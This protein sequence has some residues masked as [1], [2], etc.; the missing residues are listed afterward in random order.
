MSAVHILKCH[1]LSLLDSTVEPGYALN[2]VRASQGMPTTVKNAKVACLDINLQRYKMQM[3]VQVRYGLS[4]RC[5]WLLRFEPC[6]CPS[7]D[8][9]LLWR[10]CARDSVL[11][12]AAVGASARCVSAL[13][14]PV[15]ARPLGCFA[16]MH[17]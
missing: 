8:A 1:G 2:C 10:P 3:G 17:G 9:A 13:F 11:L 14:S 7:N 4:F 6:R 16:G 5:C 15:V 12:L